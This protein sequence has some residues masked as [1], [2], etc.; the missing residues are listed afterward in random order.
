MKPTI[1]N[2]TLVSA[3]VIG[4]VLAG[5][6]AV[7]FLPTSSKA[8]FTAELTLRCIAKY[9]QEKS[10]T[11]QEISSYCECVGSSMAS[12]ITREEYG[13]MHDKHASYGRKLVTA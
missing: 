2:I 4:L 3:A 1:T 13:A 11:E 6:V 7:E 9:G 10:F 8:A 12:L 5:K